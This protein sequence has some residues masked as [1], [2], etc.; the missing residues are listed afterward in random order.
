MSSTKVIIF[1]CHV[2][3]LLVVQIS[4]IIHDKSLYIYIFE[5]HPLCNQIGKY[6]YEG[7]DR[8]ISSSYTKETSGRVQMSSFLLLW[9]PSQPPYVS[10][11]RLTTNAPLLIE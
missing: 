4:G 5:G 3:K 8:E 6:Q 2:L 1:V 7:L 11:R 9:Y 10:S